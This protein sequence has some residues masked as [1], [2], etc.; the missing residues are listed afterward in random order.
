MFRGAECDCRLPKCVGRSALR[1]V[2]AVDVDIQSIV[3]SGASRRVESERSWLASGV[4]YGLQRPG[5]W[6]LTTVANWRRLCPDSEQTYTV[7]GMVYRS[8]GRNVS[9]SCRDQS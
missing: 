4:Q 6:L 9:E 5:C 3:A 2:N 1:P 7:M 8:S